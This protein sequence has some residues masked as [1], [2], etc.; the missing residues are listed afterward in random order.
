MDRVSKGMFAVKHLAPKILMAVNY[1]GHQ[2][3]KR[4]GWA[5]PAYHKNQGAT[6]HPGAC[7]LSLRVTGGQVGALGC[8]FDVG[9]K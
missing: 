3:T 8:V 1:C 5:A 4:L 9:F 6:L 7:N 2:L